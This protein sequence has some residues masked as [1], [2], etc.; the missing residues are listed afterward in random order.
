M[1]NNPSRPLAA[2]NR[3]Q[4]GVTMMEMVVSIV[5]FTAVA[6]LGAALISK[7]VPSYLVSSAAEKTLSA[8]EAA[9]WRLSEDFRQALLDG[10]AQTN[11]VLSLTRASGVD[12][13]YMET[14]STH[15]VIY[16]WYGSLYELRVSDPTQT[17]SPLLLNNVKSLA[18]CPFNYLSGVERARLLVNFKHT[19]G[20]TDPID[21]PV[22]TTYYSFVNGPYVASAVLGGAAIST[23]TIDGY[24]PGLNGGGSYTLALTTAGTAVSTTVTAALTSQVVANVTP[25]T[26]AVVDVK[27]TTPEGFSILKQAFTFP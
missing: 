1:S 5:L 26:S 15:E 17:V 21:I 4:R 25:I 12:G 24:F 8:R 10:T 2:G 19:N 23:V 6:S 16:E 7:L 9:L 18:G 14:V 11:C 13:A 3:R 22:S 20:A 27:V